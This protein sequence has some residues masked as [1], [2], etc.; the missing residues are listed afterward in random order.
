VY[1]VEL[2]RGPSP[3]KLQEMIPAVPRSNCTGSTAVCSCEGEIRRGPE[4]VVSPFGSP[5]GLA[6]RL[7]LK[8]STGAFDGAG[9]WTLGC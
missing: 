2:L 4:V 1:Y 3:W 6:F 7:C 5:A 9:G 8:E